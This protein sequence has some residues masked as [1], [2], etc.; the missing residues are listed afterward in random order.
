VVRVGVVDGGVVLVRPDAGGDE[1][2]VLLDEPAQ[3]RFRQ[4]VAVERVAALSL[5][6]VVEWVPGRLDSWCGWYGGPGRRV[7]VTQFPE[8][9]FGEPMVLVGE[10]DAVLRAYP[11][12]DDRFVREDGLALSLVDAGRGDRGVLMGEAESAVLL[13]REDR[14]REREVEFG[15]N[16]DVLAATL[17]TPAGS[18]PHPAAV[19]VHGAAGGG[20]DFYRLLVEPVLA[21]GIAVLLYDKPGHGRSAGSS[22]VTIFDQARAAGAALDRLVGEADIDADRLGLLGFSNGMWA[23]PM[24]AATRADVAFV[25]GVGSPG[26]SMAESEVHRRTKVLRD[27]G[28]GPDT[29]RT[30]GQAWRSIFAV[31]AAGRAEGPVVAELSAALLRLAEAE[32]LK[33]Y[34]IPSYALQNPM[35]SAVPPSMAVDE[36]L[37]MLAG[38]PDPE[39]DYDPVTDY[40][41]ISCPVLLQ[42]GEQDTSVPVEASAQRISAALPS[43][44]SATLRVYPDTEHM[45][46]VVLTDVQGVS[47]EEVMYGFHGFRFAPAVRD[48]LRDWLRTV[49]F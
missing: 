29:V 16:G 7:L 31:A 4:R 32:D 43:P 38:P 34:E 47:A 21:A 28:V 23:V 24:V 49:L 26:V 15:L 45:L 2:C 40:M 27:A 35:V 18:G 25:V 19:V 13:R 17:I 46:N 11:I 1:G 48:D 22:D 33:R 37:R 5:V 30:A 42:W 20:R 36:V 3:L 8:G 9:Y 44:R 39:L 10:G 14:Y 41:R 6:E 12:G